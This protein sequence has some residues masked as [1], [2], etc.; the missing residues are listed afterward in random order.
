[1]KTAKGALFVIIFLFL[2]ACN[3]IN[4]TP[5]QPPE[6]IEGVLDLRDWDFEKDGS[7]NLGGE[8]AF[9][10]GELLQPDQITL[11]NQNTLL[12][13]LPIV[14]WSLAFRA[15]YLTFFLRSCR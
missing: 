12:F 9:F 10:W 7:I 5:Q 11:T 15:E 1:L 14:S 13:Y 6:A 8:W 3:Q 2:T 4:S